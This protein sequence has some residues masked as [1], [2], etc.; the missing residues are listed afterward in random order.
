MS[1]LKEAAAKLRGRPETTGRIR[2]KHAL[3]VG[4]TDMPAPEGWQ[5]VKLTD[6][7]RLES[8]HTPSRRMP[9]YWEGD[10]PWIGIK[11]AADHHGRYVYNTVQHVSQAGIDN[12]AAR[13]L[14]TGT[15]CLSRTASIGY[16]TIMGRSM[17]TSQDF[18]NWVC[19]DALNPYFLLQVLL[20][21]K[22]SLFQFAYGTTHQTIYFPELKAFHI[23]L[24]PRPE[25]DRIVE[26]LSAL[27]DKIELNRHTGPLLN[28]IAD[29][30]FARRASSAERRLQAP[31]ASWVAEGMLAVGDGYRAK[32]SELSPD[33]IPFARAADVDGVV[34]VG[35]GD[36]LAPERLSLAGDKISRPLDVVVTTKGTAGRV[37]QVAASTPTVVYSPQLSFWRSLEPNRLN[38]HVLYRWMRSDAFRRQV[39]RVAGQT[40]MAPYVNLRDQRAMILDLPDADA[41]RAIAPALA[42]ID[43]R[44]AGLYAESD[45]LAAL[46]DELLP[47]LLSGE[48][49]I[50]DIERELD[51]VGA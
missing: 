8:G 12:S 9:E 37:A 24:P 51:A 26:M 17:A 41:Q 40:D 6:V 42:D 36:A 14:P 25:Q 3:S 5:W 19:S 20:A 44:I 7:A 50:P 23:C 1:E 16:A 4:L 48:L 10:I 28:V 39:D 30:V 21:E 22:E 32:N 11:D 29:T 35:S 38:P 34:R 31:V 13:L 15:V 27:D 49:R 2:G 46:R 18:A 47:R 33:G 43:A 45:Q